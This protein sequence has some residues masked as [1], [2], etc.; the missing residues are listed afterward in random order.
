M[1]WPSRARTGAASAHRR[2]RQPMISAR[3]RS[4]PGVRDARGADSDGP[5]QAGR[6]ADT[7]RRADRR[8][9]PRHHRWV[10]GMAVIEDVGPLGV[11]LERSYQVYVR[12]RLK[13]RVKQI[14][15][16]AFSVDESV[17]GFAFPQGGAGGARRERAAQVP[18]AVSV[19]HALR[20]WTRP[21]P[22]N[23]S[24]TLGAWSSPRSSPV[25]TTPAVPG[26]GAASRP[27]RR[28]AAVRRPRVAGPSAT[29]PS[30][31]PC[32]ARRR[33]AGRRGGRCVPRRRLGRR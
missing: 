25:P 6:V 29:G 10:L 22:A 24:S 11:G 30:P 15:Y 33:S 28:S 16:V 19:G 17:M 14:V 26:R 12:G 2:T 5:D 27:V 7:R 13:F 32:R 4:Q 20:H 21:K 3:R 23:S 8:P 31:C 18:D 9:A 1:L